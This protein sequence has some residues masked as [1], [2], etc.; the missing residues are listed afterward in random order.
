AE[1]LNEGKTKR[2]FIYAIGEILL[3]MIGILLAFQVDS[4]NDDWLRRKQELNYY[5]NVREQLVHDRLSIIGNQQFNY[6]YLIQFEHAIDIIENNDRTEIDSLG[7]IIINLTE[8][9]DFDRQGNIYETLVTGGEIKLLKNKDIIDGI[10]NL[11]GRYIYMNRMEN[12]HWEV[13]MQD[14][15]PSIGD[16]LK[17]RSAQIQQPDMVYSYRFQNLIIGLQSIMQE[18][19]TIYLETNRSIKSLIGIIDQE[20]E[21]K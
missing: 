2:Y 13:I 4:W 17:F 7:K 18:K 16:N 19:D 21:D 10:R 3:V 5:K 14:V 20:L 6:R 9:S 15:L 11:E 1:L 12:I 8:Y